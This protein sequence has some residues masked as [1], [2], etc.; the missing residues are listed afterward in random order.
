MICQ[1]WTKHMGVSEIQTWIAD[2]KDRLFLY[3]L[4]LTLDA[5]EAEDLLQDT[6]ESILKS[7]AQY[8]ESK[9]SLLP[10][11]KTILRNQ[12][13]DRKR[14]ENRAPRVIPFDET[15]EIGSRAIEW[16]EEED[17]IQAVR[18]IIQ[19]LKEPEK[20]IIQLKFYE[21]KTLDQIASL[22]GLNRR[23]ISRRYAKVLSDL[24][25]TI[26]RNP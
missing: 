26:L 5:N 6:Y 4:H 2:H 21:K 11:A 9:G 25:Q 22:L 24:R 8:S 1:Q 13:I 12:F 17:T 15:L 10:W 19:S 20:S 16:D 3:A 18:K 23:T 7:F 14:K